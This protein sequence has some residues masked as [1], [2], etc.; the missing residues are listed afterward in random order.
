MRPESLHGGEIARK[1]LL[2]EMGMDRLVADLVEAYLGP[3][4]MA[5]RY[6]VMPV[7]RRPRRQ[8]TATEGARVG[9]GVVVCHRDR[10]AAI[11]ADGSRWSAAAQETMS[12][13]G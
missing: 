11:P 9:T 8:G 13:A 4:A 12:N 6:Q 2:A 7:G 10:L 1:F 3:A 5:P